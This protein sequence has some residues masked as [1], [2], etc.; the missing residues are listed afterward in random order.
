MENSYYKNKLICTYDLKDDNGL[1]YEDLVLEWK[2]AAAE[3]AL[4]CADCGAPVYLAAGPIKEPYF[5]HYDLGSCSYGNGVES[6][7]LKKGKR[8]LYQLLRR[9]FPDGE[10]RAR[11]RM[12]NGMYATLFCVTKEGSKLAFDYR[13]VNNSL[14]KYRLRDDYYQSNNIKPIYILG[15]RQDKKVQQIDWYQSLIQSS[16]GYLAF[17]D[18][19]KETLVLKK[20]L[21]YRLGKER[22]FKLYGKSYPISELLID[23]NGQMLCDFPE[24]CAGIEHEIAEEKRQYQLRQDKLKELRELRER[25]E[26][27]ERSRMEAYRDSM[28]PESDLNPVLLEKCRKMIA[29]GNGYLVSKK[30]YDAIMREQS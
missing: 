1:Y 23:E 12:E 14:E 16:M 7:E 5:A 18:T 29:E 9:S 11:Y 26:E 10:L 15:I 3:H 30:Y 21:S 22:K 17:L 28:K 19:G 27:E 6:E 4:T 2:Q 8:L 25:M 24:Q 13:L 20:G